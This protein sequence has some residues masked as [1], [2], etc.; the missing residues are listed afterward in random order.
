MTENPGS[1]TTLIFPA[2]NQAAIDYV[3]ASRDRGESVVC[4]ASVY[5]N[6]IAAICPKL[7]MLPSIHDHDFERRF[8]SMLE[9]LSIS[10]LFCPV[11][12]A[13]AY[14]ARFIQAHRL[15]VKMIGQSPV[16][17]QIEQ[18]HRLVH[19]AKQ[20]LPH[21]VCCA[22]GHPALTLREVAGALRQT[23]LI[24]GES[25]DDKLAAMMGI[26]ACAPKGDVIEIG[27]LMGRSAF[28]MLYLARRYDIGPL[29]TVDPWSARE[30][31]QRDSPDALQTV[32]DEWDY[33]VLSEG[34]YMNIL[35]LGTRD[36]A[37]LRMPST[38]AFEVYENGEAIFSQAG[39][40]VLFSGSISVIHID[41]NHDYDSVNQDCEFW[42]RKMI[43]GSWLILDDYIWAHGDGPY[44]VGNSL[45]N[46]H[47]NRIRRAFVCGK[48]LF[49]NFS[50]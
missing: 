35:P 38:G 9:E 26:F 50:H 22:D 28:L 19:R 33:E 6:E 15:S 39:S 46:E 23:L 14:L 13:Y 32:T 47:Q 24:Y 42:L 48:A 2:V 11:S 34:F 43:P 29:L 27:S 4:A 12:T 20:L 37:H 40:P 3:M 10:R 49:V 44:R 36:H 1:S 45:L 31:I 7:H 21:V 25:N 30:C 17:Q 18:H 8:L 41:G 16:Q 5:S